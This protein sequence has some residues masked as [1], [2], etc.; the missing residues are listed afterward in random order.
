MTIEVNEDTLEWLI[1]SLFMNLDTDNLEQIEI[2]E[3]L[4]S[5]QNENNA[6]N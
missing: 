5:K 6:S 2:I 1:D 3:Y 4:E